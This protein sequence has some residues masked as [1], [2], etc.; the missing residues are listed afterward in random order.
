MK[1]T[2]GIEWLKVRLDAN[3]LHRIVGKL[4]LRR[5]IVGREKIC[6]LCGNSKLNTSLEVPHC[7]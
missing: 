2:K 5:C 7:L 4:S 6:L 3:V 1:S